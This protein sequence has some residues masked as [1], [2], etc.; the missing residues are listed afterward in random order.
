MKKLILLNLAL[1]FLATTFQSDNPPGW[2]VQTL[3]VNDIVND[4]FFLDSLNGWLVTDG[5]FSENDTSYIMRTSNG[6]DNWTIQNAKKE[7]L[8]TIQF[9]DIN[10]GYAAGGLNGTTSMS[11]YKTSNGGVNW[12]K[13]NNISGVAINDMYF[14]DI[15]TG[16]ICD[17]SVIVGGLYKTTNGGVTWVQQL[18]V[19]YKI[20]KIFF[21]NKDTGWVGNNDGILYKTIDSGLNWQQVYDFPGIFDVLG[22]QFIDLNT[23]WLTTTAIFKSTNGGFNWEQYGGSEVG[24]EY[25]FVSSH[26]GWASGDNYRVVKTTNGGINWLY[27]T[28]PIENSLSISAVDSLKA[29]GGGLGI[30]HTTDGGLTGIETITEVANNF[31]L[32]QNY[33]NPYNPITKIRYEL[34]SQSNVSLIIYDISGRIIKELVNQNQLHGEYSYTFDGTDISSGVYFYKLSTENFTETKKMILAK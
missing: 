33:P 26:T 9:L 23:G 34:Q 8:T 27:Q 32:H 21:I 16:W 1:L 30:I 12:L 2:Y 10:T 25:S 31:I 7:K 24:A 29:W 11:F 22:M 15:N 19:N 13:L 18:D 5:R 28:I 17:P 14:T 3:P 20:Q 4:I 6:G